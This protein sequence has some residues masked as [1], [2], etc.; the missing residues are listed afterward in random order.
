[1]LMGSCKTLLI[2][3]DAVG[4]PPSYAN[5]VTASRNVHM[6]VGIMASHRFYY[7]VLSGIISSS[8]MVMT[9][10]T[11]I[12][13]LGMCM[14]RNPRYVTAFRNVGMRVAIMVRTRG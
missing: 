5:Y 2:G 6:D 12:A 11:T 4:M 13:I 7:A 8:R 3:T 10:E 1:M 9:T 14:T